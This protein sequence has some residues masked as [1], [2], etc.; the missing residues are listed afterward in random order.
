M[1]NISKL[2]SPGFGTVVITQQKRAFS[3]VTTEE[4]H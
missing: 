4:R 3:T 1:K 2:S